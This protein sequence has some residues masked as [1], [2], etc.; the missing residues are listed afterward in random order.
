MGSVECKKTSGAVA[1]TLFILW[2]GIKSKQNEKKLVAASV[3]RTFYMQ[4][5][6][7]LR[8]FPLKAIAINALRFGVL[9]LWM[10]KKKKKS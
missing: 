10:K 4:S 9:L 7:G 5:L 2:G 3:T 8:E 6:Q 1:E